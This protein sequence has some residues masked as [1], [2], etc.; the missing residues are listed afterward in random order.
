MS[1]HLIDIGSLKSYITDHRATAHGILHRIASA[2]QPF[3]LRSQVMDVLDRLGESDG[4]IDATELDTPLT[5]ML[6]MVQ[7]AAHDG[8][9]LCL[10]L[11]PR[12]GRWS[13]LR[14]LLDQ[15]DVQ[16]IPVREYL[17][18]KEHLV[19][20]NRSSDDWTLEIDF[21]P[22]LRDVL[23]MR[24][25]RSIG[26]G[27]EFLNRRLSSQIFDTSSV[28]N[29][30]AGDKKLLEFLRLH[31][32]RGQ[33]LMLNG[34]IG[35][36][37]GLR[38]ALRNALERLSTFPDETP[39]ASFVSVMQTLG[40]E[41]GWGRTAVE[42]SDMMRCLQD[43]LE[44]PTPVTIENFLK[45]VPMIFSV[46]ILSPHGWF[47]QTNVL[48]RPDTGGQVVYILDQVRAL[49]REMRER[50]ACQGLDIEPQIIVVTRLI[51]EAEGTSANE[52]KEMI[53]GT[54]NA[55]ILRVPFRHADG[56]V[57]KHWLSRF[58][59]WPYLER[60]SHD[61][62]RELLAELSARPDLIVGNYSDGNLVAT[63]LSNRLKVTQCNVAHALEKTKYL[64]SDLYWKDNDSHYHFSCQF[65]ADLIAMNAADFIITSTYQEIA[66]T[67]N[68]VG[69]YESHMAY[70][71]P[72][73]YRV[74]SGIDAFDPKFN[75]VSPGADT[76]IFFPATDKARRLP[77]LIE[78]IDELVF[79]EGPEGAYRGNFTAPEKPL[80]LTMARMDR[81]KNITG[82]ARWFGESPE[83][84]KHCNLLIVSGHV[85]AARSSDNEERDQIATMHQ[86]MDDLQLDGQVRWLGMHLEKALSGEL[87]R[88]VAESRGAF[89]Q[90]ALFEAFGLTV[91]EAMA[92]GL[93]VFA[94]CFG[95]PLE[96]IEDGK[97][98]YHIDPN[99]G[100]AAAE[101]IGAF[102][103]GSGEDPGL[104]DRISDG[105][106]ARV[107]ARYTWAR[108]AERLMTLSR[109]YGF[110]RHITD[111]ERT[112][113]WRYLEMF[114][115]LQYRP[116][117]EKKW[118]AAE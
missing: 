104:W 35:D 105:A 66:G 45:R 109:I 92:T 85:D 14:I 2:G 63:L 95:G 87:Y 1:Q 47:G 117:V 81:I 94:T 101:K 108:Y 115:G 20:P 56:S 37:P 27:V 97:S 36:V 18:F 22:F 112:E 8:A 99:H 6:R 82:L 91:I 24:E 5:N 15:L 93:P 75:I 107:E 52:R 51:P 9:T 7:D 61:C 110:W 38:E 73:L 70:T 53:A 78:Q 40:F 62:E 58:E 50:L 74:V 76:D 11:R 4:G 80:L 102:M 48:G 106:I 68:T 84:R 43:I 67:R 16:D 26:S 21:E 30:S 116:L 100:D 77:H 12:I 41:V 29:G 83:L 114:Y 33:Q 60:F 90:P 17:A 3:L 25:S 59:I 13:Y 98:G 10:A 111:L 28:R 72:G 88:F 64:Y 55:Y 42:V 34:L 113:T 57:H 46:V 65:T 19:D 39:W 54:R 49:E 71:M 86:M 79:G 23:K 32:W 89:V 44:A 69:Q 96:I 31:K 118:P 103:A